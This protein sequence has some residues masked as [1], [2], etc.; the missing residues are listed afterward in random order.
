MGRWGDKIYKGDAPLDYLLTITDKFDQELYRLFSPGE[1]NSQSGWLAQTLTIIE[2]ILLFELQHKGSSIYVTDIKEVER[3]RDTFFSI[4]DGDW[5]D[6]LTY[7]NIFNDAA[8]RQQH[9][10][11]L[12]AIFDCLRS[13]AQSRLGIAKSGVQPEL[14]PL[15]PDY[16]LPYFSV[17]RWLDN[18]NSEIFK[19][20]RFISDLLESLV[21]DIIYWLSAEKRAEVITFNVEEVWVAADVLGFL[22]EK[23]KQSPGIHEKFIRNWRET[24]VD[25]WKQNVGDDWNESYSL[26]QEVLS[27]F[28]HLEA[29]AR[30]YPTYEW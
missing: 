2:L 17:T 16:P 29:V 25:I 13:I 30:Q 1:N 8:Y 20:E 19:V 10:P 22:C 5:K 4:W 26:Y 24:T 3:W 21:K 15:H 27:V 28:D 6:S 12:I 18:D 9:R 23:Y 14:A 11:A 7:D